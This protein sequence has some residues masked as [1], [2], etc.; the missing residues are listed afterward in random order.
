MKVTEIW[1]SIIIPILIGPL[2]IYLKTLYDN[3]IKNKNQHTMMIYNYKYEKLVRILNNF[4]WPLYI[5]LLCIN[6]L[7]YYIPLKNSYEY[8]SDD[9]L[10]D[11]SNNSNNSNDSNNTDVRINIIKKNSI[12]GHISDII[13]DRETIELMNINLNNL[14]NSALD[15]IENYIHL[16]DN[17]NNTILNLIDFIKYCKLRPIIH[18][19]TL[20]KKYNIEYFGIKN[21]INT[22]IELIKK[23]TFNTQHKFNILVKKGPFN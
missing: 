6:Q 5:K 2:F 7:N 4:Y 1:V 8:K 12:G 11:D 21:N 3:Y 19:G 18:D 15:I 10:S 20:K 14:Y 23:E 13:L 22:L 9:S 17:S 16:I